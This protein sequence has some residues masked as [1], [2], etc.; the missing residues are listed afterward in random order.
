M[1]WE[2]KLVCFTLDGNSCNI[3]LADEAHL[4]VAETVRG[5]EN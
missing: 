5:R 1:F 3:L 4:T 2:S